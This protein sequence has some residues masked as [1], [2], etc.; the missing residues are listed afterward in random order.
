LVFDP[1]TAA[2]A[3]AVME[4]KPASAELR[5]IFILDRLVDHPAVAG[6]YLRAPNGILD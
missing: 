5:A 3:I 1:P 2:I 6:A 4:S